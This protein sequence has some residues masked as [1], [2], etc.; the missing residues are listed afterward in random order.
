MNELIV[1]TTERWKKIESRGSCQAT[2]HEVV[3]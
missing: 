1:Y 3:M 2:N